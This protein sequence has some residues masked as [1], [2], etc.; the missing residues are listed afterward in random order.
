MSSSHGRLS[1]STLCILFALS[2]LSACSS[3]DNTPVNQP[4]LSA[5]L[6][7]PA[8]NA[9]L[10][11]W[12]KAELV[13][14]YRYRDLRYYYAVAGSN[15]TTG[16]ATTASTDSSSTGTTAA[17]QAHGGGAAE[18][19]S[20]TNVQEKGVDE[21]DLVKN[22]GSH[23]YLARGSHFLVLKG[24]PVGEAAVISDID[25][26]E[27]ISELHLA[28]SRITVIT[29]P[30]SGISVPVASPGGVSAGTGA[31]PPAGK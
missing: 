13:K 29:T 9:A 16:V 5:R 1:F 20:S 8:D 17:P 26:K 3:H 10:E 19:F 21:G 18:S 31:T 25:L 11:R 23:I 2:A 27:Q 7:N 6:I 30:G 4:A 12:L 28:G 15:G 14:N 22:D 24:Q